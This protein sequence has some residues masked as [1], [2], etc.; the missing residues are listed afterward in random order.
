MTCDA[1]TYLTVDAV[2]N[3]AQTNSNPSV[4]TF[5]MGMVNTTGKIGFYLLYVKQLTVD[6]KP[7]AFLDRILNGSGESGYFPLLR[8]RPAAWS[9]SDGSSVQSGKVFAADIGVVARLDSRE[10]MNGPIVDNAPIDGS[11]TLNF[12]YGI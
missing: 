11:T 2:D 8:G 4:N 1:E 5:G 10:K 7:A 6:S 3:R 12:A 9:T